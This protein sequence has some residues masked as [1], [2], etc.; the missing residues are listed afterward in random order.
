MNNQDW[1]LYWRNSLADADSAKGALKKQ[2]LKNYVRATT[3]EFKEG[4]LKPDSKL[5]QDLF[6]NEEDTLNAVEIHYRPVTY[7]LRKVHGKDYKNNMPD[8]LTPIVCTL[9]VNRE[10]LLFPHTTPFISRDLLAPQG[11]DAF[12]IAEVDKLDEFLTENEIP[13]Q[14]TESI[15]AKFEQKE[16]YQNHQKEWQNYYELTQQL[17]ADYCDRSRIDQFYEHIESGGLVNKISDCLGVSRHILKLYDKLSTSNTALPLID[18]YATKTVIN[19]EECI[20][21]SQTVNSRLGHSNSQFPLAKAQC[22]ALAH[23]LA[24]QEGDILAVNGPPG[25][26]KTTFVLS[27]VA[28][29]WIESALK[30]SKPPLIIAA[31]TNNQAVTNII[32]AFGK[33]FDEGDDEL[34][35]RWIPNIFSYGGYLPSAYGAVEAAKSYQTNYFYEKIEQLDFLDQAQAHYLERAKQAF[36]EENFDDV[37]QVKAY[38]LA[39]LRQHKKKLDHIQNNWNQYN[40]QLN[41]IYSRLGENPQQALA[42]QRQVVSNAQ[43][44]KD[45]AK[46]H[47]TAWRN[48]LGKESIWLTLFKWLPPIKNKLELQRRSFMLNLIKHDE[49]QIENQSS[50]FFESLLKGVFSSKKNDFDNQKKRYQSN[51]E[52]YQ[53][54]EQSRLNWL[55]AIHDFTEDSTEQTIPHLTDIDSLL[56]ITTRF[57]MFRLSVHYWEACWLLSCRGM[58][59][60]LNKQARKTGLKTVR[61]RWQRRMMLTPCIV[62][63]F[64]SLPSHM[65]YQSH[66]G[67]N[68]FESDYLLNEIDLLIVDEAGQVAPEV[69]AASFS[70]AKKALVIGDIYQISPIRSVCSSIDRGNLKQHKIISSDEDYPVIQEEGR[71]VVTGSV[72]HIAQQA[73]RFHYMQQAQPGMF[74]QEHRRCYDELISYCNDLCYQGILIPKRGQAIEDSL[75]SPFSHVHVD[76]IAESFSG[77]RRNKLEAETIAAW[78]H[79]KKVEIENYYGEPLFKCVGIITPFSAQVNQIKTACGEFDIKAGKAEDQLTVGTVH[80][81]QGAERKIIIFSQVYTRHNDGGFIDMDPSMLNVAVSRAKDAFLVFG[82]LDII[83]AAPSCSPRGLLAKHLFTDERNELEFSVGQ[84]P[85][86]LQICSHPKLLTNTEEHDAFLS[87]LLSEVQR[88]ID[89][90]SPWLLLDKVQSTGQL[91]LLKAALN[92]G[93]QIT[94]HTDR[95]FNTTVANHLDTN[96]IKAFQHCCAILEQLGIVINVINGV[97]SKCIFADERYMAVGSFNWFSASRGGKYTNI[98]TSLIYVGE[99]EKE[100]KTQLDF[101][102]SRG[103][104]TNKHIGTKSQCATLLP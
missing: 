93:V 27:V 91:E 10:G 70:L 66:V 5:L 104:S 81:L 71:S 42:A 64:H 14:S 35:G 96:K 41:E 99:L 88:K 17:F 83:E 89:I 77:S 36:P 9:Y 34:S 19:H 100:I 95:H 63:T 24:M 85:D 69:A 98:E 3:N 73:S 45:N 92:R 76:G 39:E 28:S 33:D 97:H 82:D 65:S 52:Q 51:L 11:N 102:N 90:V 46:K 29:M 80:S 58:G 103:C 40:R 31:S 79:A 48:Y 25:T 59:Q 37:T 86:L 6:H 50:D 57:R 2:E 55:D 94:I 38:L 101:L 53:E 84:R 23:T 16:Q 8:V 68:E 4:K 20:D 7:Y 30:E 78:L 32:D 72:M 75:Y 62:S 21:V 13:K 56:D 54:F 15:S 43:V 22:D 18:S 44:L 12:T 1:I 74:L 61:P 67:N 26:G 87:K 60:D 49:E 47:L